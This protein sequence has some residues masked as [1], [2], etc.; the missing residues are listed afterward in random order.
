MNQGDV[1]NYSLLQTIETLYPHE[2]V[3]MK[4]YILYGSNSYSVIRNG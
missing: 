1:I 4:V 3:G 2:H